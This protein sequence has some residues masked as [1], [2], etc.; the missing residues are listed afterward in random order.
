MKALTF[1]ISV[2]LPIAALFAVFCKLF[3]ALSQSPQI[4]DDFIIEN[5]SQAGYNKSA[6]I[7]LFRLIAAG[8]IL[9]T[10][11]LVFLLRKFMSSPVTAP[12]QKMTATGNTPAF[13]ALAAFTGHLIVFGKADTACLIGLIAATGVMLYENIRK[14]RSAEL[15][16]L[17]IVSYY[18]VLAALTV[19]V[20]ISPRFALS[21]NAIYTGAGVL[22]ILALL[23]AKFARISVKKIL[24]ILQL[25]V[26]F[27][28]AL[29]FVDRYAYQGAV[30]RVPYA[31]FYYVFFGGLLLLFLLLTVVHIR[32]NLK[33]ADSVSI[34]KLI[35]PVTAIVI[36]IYN[37][38]SACPM[39]AQPDQ[40]HHGE[41][42][43][44]W[45]QIIGLGQTAYE[46]YTPVSG[47]FPMVN[48][49]IQNVLLGGT[50]S[51]YSPAISI[52]VVI[53][54]ILTMYLISRHVGGARAL[55]FAVFFA[56]PAYNR[57]YM[58]LPVLL[59]LF[60]KELTKKPGLWLKVWLLSCFAAGLYYPLYG[61]AVLVGTLPLGIGMLIRFMKETDW[62][63]E[64][65]NPRFYI[66][67]LVCLA[68][69]LLALPLL[70]RMLSHTLVYSGQTILADGISLFG[71]SAPDYF[72]PYLAGN[73]ENIRLWLYY[74]LRF[75][76]PILPLA[77]GAGLFALILLSQHENK[78]RESA[79]DR[80]MLL[81]GLAAMML[82]LA[83]SYSYTLVRAD[84][85]MILSRTAPVLIAVMGMFLPVLLIGYGK[86][87]LAASLRAL[88]IG[89]CFA[90]PMMIY[91][92]VSSM[93][94]PDMWVYPN[95]E[96]SLV[97]DD[98][99]KLFHH[100]EVPETFISMHEISLPDTSMLGNGFMVADQIHYLTGYA[101]VMEKAGAKDPDI[102]YMGM[103]G[104]GFYYYL[105]AKVCATGFIQAGKGY[106]AQQ[107]ILENIK[108][109]RPVV[110]LLEPQASYYIYRYVL[111]E[112]YIYKAEDGAFYP[113]EL[114]IKIY[115]DEP[116]DDYRPVCA[117]T[118]LGLSPASFGNSADTLIGSRES[119]VMFEVPVQSK[120]L[121]VPGADYDL[122]MLSLGEQLA[123]EAYSVEIRFLCDN[124]AYD[125]AVVSCRT[126]A[127]TLLIP[128][129]MNPC[130]LLSENSKITL[131]FY[132]AQGTL[133][134]EIPLEEISSHGILGRFYRMGR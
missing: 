12:K 66:G 78:H 8:C 68:P 56:L 57:Q 55:V 103:D 2:C 32:Q 81:F 35:H 5:V 124:N 62:K 95:G 129:G 29:F 114:Y 39:Y 19:L 21:Q 88:L 54:C 43:I 20:H 131:H 85:N 134:R 126:G 49:F 63:T 17:P 82:S 102:S 60:L 99:D 64:R 123:A 132:D 107:L 15:L 44:P 87:F 31:P 11:L 97:M 133:I 117:G 69:V 16:V 121:T 72:L 111:L 110:F 86:K 13:I 36:F 10:V 41:Q 120:P 7:T 116:G 84:T 100:Y 125:G 80:R 74:G 59:L 113:S 28:L 83:V 30:I 119:S 22:T 118:D 65:K 104:Q 23:I 106:D 89:V 58:V 1:A 98:A 27:L 96:A 51:D 128:L 38:Y 122:L 53:F 108:K 71:Q 34:S 4:F 93:K 112:D 37:S 91:A 18:A 50:V 67:W 105:N 33:N 92:R 101:S 9:L 42:L 45:Q 90:L 115:P 24:L 109:E 26:P 76:L 73:H 46:E 79:T 127:G 52:M 48:G 61:A 6:E 130:W 94:F 47:L 40:H 14:T 77:I 70:F 75:F 3:P 25:A